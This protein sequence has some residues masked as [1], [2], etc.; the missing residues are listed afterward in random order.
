MIRLVIYKNMK[1]LKKGDFQ[2]IY[3]YSIVAFK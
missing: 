3:A 2:Y 1:V